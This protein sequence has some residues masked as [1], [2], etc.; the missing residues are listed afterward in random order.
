MA[1]KAGYPHYMLKE[2]FE[3][4]RAVQDTAAEWLACETQTL[5]LPDIGLA[6]HD[7]RS[8]NRVHIV[9]SGTSRHAGLAAKV[10][11]QELAGISAEVHYASEFQYCS[12]AI[13]SHDLT[14]S[15][16]QSG[17]TADTIAALAAAADNGSKS[18]AI[19]NVVGS[20]IARKANAVIYTRA[21]EEVA[22]ASTKAFTAQ[23]AVLFLFSLYLG[24][25]RGKLSP[26][27]AQQYVREMMAIPWKLEAVL[28][29][30]S[31]CEALAEKYFLASDFL[32]LGSGVHLPAALDG[33]LKLKEVSYIHAEG[34]AIGEIKHGPYALIDATM[35]CVF[36]AGRDPKDAGSLRRYA[37]AVQSMR[38]V[39]SKQGR[40][41]AIAVEGSEEVAAITKE[42]IFIP[43][44]PELLLPILEIV[45][46]QLLAYFIGVRRGSN[47]DN[48]R[49]LVKAVT[50]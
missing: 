1:D 10:M 35:P 28:E 50:E 11:L 9:A 6:G 46:L 41:I 5:R 44:A 32:F 40:V 26:Q 38:E 7:L 29:R 31:V 16:T 8:L 23:L 3:S 25:L 21:G 43:A 12:P 13:G 33:A 19:C 45:P 2:I 24:Q 14:I 22:I 27:A 49:N 36:L 34:Y 17:E 48:P 15:I 39:K 4:P 30:R 20:T 18:L 37:M 42:I 47:V